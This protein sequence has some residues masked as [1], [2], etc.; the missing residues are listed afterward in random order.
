M[1]VNL[2]PGSTKTSTGG[3]V[4]KHAAKIYW[5]YSK[6]PSIHRLFCKIQRVIQKCSSMYSRSQKSVPMFPC[7]FLEKQIF[8]QVHGAT[9]ESPWLLPALVAWPACGPSV[10]PW[11][12][13][14]SATFHGISASCP[15]G[16]TY[17]L[18]KREN[19]YCRLLISVISYLW[20]CVYEVI[21]CLCFL[22]VFFS[23]TC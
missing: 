8:F 5:I 7:I 23:L 15:V 16:N 20:F 18:K 3:Y 4:Q 11:R 13:L 22:F 19:T 17:W 10:A 14:R 12:R 21:F 2:F 1:S 9:P 6:A